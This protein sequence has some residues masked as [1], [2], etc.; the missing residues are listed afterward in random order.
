MSE[1]RGEVDLVVDRVV[2]A[3]V[4]QVW[5]GW[6]DPEY[7]E[8]WWA[9][10]GFTMSRVEMDV[11]EHGT[12]LICIHSPEEDEDY[13]STWTY[14]GIQPQRRLEF[15]AGYSD[16]D[17]NKADP[18][19]WGV[20]GVPMEVPTEVRFEPIGQGR[21]RVTYVEHGHISEEECEPL[22]QVIGQALDRMAA[23]FE[24]A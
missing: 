14:H 16:V 9:D 18:A 15:I 4:E 10:E 5:Q 19:E 13:C 17:Y 8:Q 20:E 2:D 24:T 11:R 23:L 6:T 1:N 7:V 22:R 12:S 3:P 21:T